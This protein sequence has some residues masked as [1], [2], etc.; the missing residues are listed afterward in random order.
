[1]EAAVLCGE[2]PAEVLQADL[3]EAYR[4]VFG[5]SLAAEFGE[6]WREFFPFPQIPGFMRRAPVWPSTRD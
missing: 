3:D 6:D 4:E 5:R 1:M 2:A